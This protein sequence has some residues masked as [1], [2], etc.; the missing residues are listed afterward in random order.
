[1][2][3]VYKT[4]YDELTVPS[5]VRDAE[6]LITSPTFNAVL[7]ADLPYHARKELYDSSLAKTGE[8]LYKT[9]TFNFQY[10]ADE[11]SVLQ[12]ALQTFA[13]D[14]NYSLGS[15]DLLLSYS[16]TIYNCFSAEELSQFLQ[17]AS[18]WK[19]EIDQAKSKGGKIEGANP[20]D[21]IGVSGKGVGKIP[22]VDLLF[23]TVDIFGVTNEYIENKNKLFLIQQNMS[24]YAEQFFEISAQASEETIKK[25][26]GGLAKACNELSQNSSELE[27]ILS[28]SYGQDLG[29]I[30]ANTIGSLVLAPLSSASGIASGIAN[31]VIMNME[32]HLDIL[33]DIRNVIHLETPVIE[34]LRKDIKSFTEHPTEKNATGLMRQYELLLLLRIRGL[35]LENQAIINNET[36]LLSALKQNNIAASNAIQTNQYLIT[37]YKKQLAYIKSPQGIVYT[38]TQGAIA[39]A[40][41][42]ATVD[43]TGL[44][45]A[46]YALYSANKIL[47]EM[48][49]SLGGLLDSIL[50]YWERTYTSA[51]PENPFVPPFDSIG[52]MCSRMNFVPADLHPNNELYT[53]QAVC[54]AVHEY[55]ETA[56]SRV[57]QIFGVASDNKICVNC[58]ALAKA[59]ETSADSLDKI[60]QAFRMEQAQV[61]SL[62]GRWQSDDYTGLASI[63]TE[64][65]EKLTDMIAALSSLC[66]A[67][68]TAASCYGEAQ[69]KSFY[70]FQRCAGA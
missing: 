29:L 33:E 45:G 22:L 23:A 67:L 61:Q 6:S 37:E 47:E 5:V 44:E 40:L 53:M 54:N 13:N 41:P 30:L 65:T 35:E 21:A 20:Y 17:D 49:G 42:Q 69:N 1:M 32:G 18:E 68:Q 64:E 27:R 63:V 46:A 34:Q 56:F 26:Y 38:K 62:K 25:V 59:G 52:G 16:K 50:T 10:S 2:S 3:G 36:A 70:A 12:T 51:D 9:A 48:Y 55:W 15:D 66:D 4:V 8:V 7:N 24:K 43:L 14:F 28:Q 60:K 39:K 58:S 11:A 31:L 19:K 57:S